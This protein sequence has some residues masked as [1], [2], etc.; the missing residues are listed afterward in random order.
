MKLKQFTIN[1]HKFVE[2]DAKFWQTMAEGLLKWYA[3]TRVESDG[4]RETKA[5]ICAKLAG[6][7]LAIHGHFTAAVEALSDTGSPT[8]LEHGMHSAK[9][10]ERQT[11]AMEVRAERLLS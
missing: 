9:I 5:V 3:D 8:M 7:G 1:D 4:D 6:L 2:S 10:G 11:N